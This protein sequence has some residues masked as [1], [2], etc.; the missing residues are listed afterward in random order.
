MT[1]IKSIPMAIGAVILSAGSV[2]AFSALPSAATP[3][4]TKAGTAS[5]KTVPVRTVSDANN[6][7]EDIDANDQGEDTDADAPETETP[8]AEAPETE[9]PDT[10]APDTGDAP[11]AGTHGAAVS[12]VAQAPDTTPD[13]N[14]GADVSAVARDNHGLTTATAKK[15]AHLKTGTSTKKPAHTGK[16]G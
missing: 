8:D 3:G 1:R 10:E 14:H 15:A 4:L 11:K 13:T 5:G 2:F 6:Q 12:A 9:T 16:P 7:G